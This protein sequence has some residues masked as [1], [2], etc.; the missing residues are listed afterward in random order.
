MTHPPSHLQ[1]GFSVIEALAAV[2]LLAVALAPVYDMLQ[3]LSDAAS[4]ADDLVSAT[5]VLETTSALIRAGEIP[6][7]QINGWRVDVTRQSE[8]EPLLVDGYLG[9]Q[10]FYVSEIESLITVQDNDFRLQRSIITLHLD[11]VYDTPEEAIFSQF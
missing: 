7:E 5:Q 4:R 9:G 8:T 11:P 6:P 1:D 3:Q 10:F 2:A